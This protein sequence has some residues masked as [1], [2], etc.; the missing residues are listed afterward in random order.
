MRFKI[1]TK[2]TYEQWKEQN[3]IYVLSVLDLIEEE[4][5]NEKDDDDND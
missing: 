1:D 3:K 5:N 2:Q 4:E